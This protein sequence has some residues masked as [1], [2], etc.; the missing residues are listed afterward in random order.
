VNVFKVKLAVTLAAAL[1]VTLQG[2]VPEQP[3]PL[4]PVKFELPAGVAV[5]VTTVPLL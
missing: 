5:K 3:A 4:Q 2:P 1:M